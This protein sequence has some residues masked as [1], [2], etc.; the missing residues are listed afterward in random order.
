MRN[1]TI[2]RELAIQ[3]LYQLDLRG[4]EILGEIESFCKR[5]TE[6]HD[7]YQFAIALTNGCRSHLKEID[8][9]ISMVT[10][11]WELRRMAIIDK[12]ILRLGVYEL[13]YRNDIPP[14]VSINEAIELAKKFSTKNSGTFVNGILDK[15]YTQGGDGKVKGE[16]CPP[17]L[18]NVSEVQYGNAD[19]HIHT[20]YSDGT[21]TPEEVV[22]DAL[23]R[24]VSTI[25]ITDHDTVDGLVIALRYG[26]G[27]NIHI[28]SGIEFSSYL[29]PSEVHILGYFIDVN[30][31]SL[32][33][34]I[35]QSRD[36]RVNRIH[37]MVDKLHALHVD[38]D[39]QEILALA[40]QGSP[41]RMH[42]AETLWKH[43]YCATIIESFTKYIG[44]NKPAY[45]PKKTLTSQQAIEL[46]RDAGGVAVLAHP[47]L[48]QR[49]HII[50]DLVQY[51]LQGIEVYYPS[52]SPQTVR[53]YLK[54]AK[55]YDLAVTGGSDFH[56]ERRLD[57]PIAKITI[58]GDL[59]DKLRQR[60]PAR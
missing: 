7:V 54:V 53:K 16:A 33:K 13:L 6:K 34:M 24:G 31:I 45:V 2:A 36:D 43:G 5:S 55:K 17:P 58:P 38:I 42:V 19:L 12:N 21:M 41:G 44:D 60:C 48:T 18:Q 23:R 56:G 32:Q 30:N 20:N 40:G 50:G 4:D 9:K 26:Q 8:E 51:G 59:V 15:I 1:R 29:S 11:H 47:G 27:K 39:A 37:D 25:S 46:I 22:D 10:E 49:D 28:I 35:R 57:C 52:H 3:A 14:K